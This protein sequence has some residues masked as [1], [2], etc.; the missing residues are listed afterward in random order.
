MNPRERAHRSALSTVAVARPNLVAI[1]E[2]ML[3]EK[4]GVDPISCQS[5]GDPRRCPNRSVCELTGALLSSSPSGI[6]RGK[7]KEIQGPYCKLSATQETVKEL[8]PS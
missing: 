8:V 5:L 3:G 2:I 1:S 6:R 7:E 4:V